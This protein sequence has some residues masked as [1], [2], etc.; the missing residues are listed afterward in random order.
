MSYACDN[1]S[2]TQ[3]IYY[4]GNENESKGMVQNKILKSGKNPPFL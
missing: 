1:F 3:V 2:L 4:F